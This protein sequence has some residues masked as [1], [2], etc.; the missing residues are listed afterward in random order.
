MTGVAPGEALTT[1]E[2]TLGLAHL[3]TLP[4]TL[5]IWSDIS[6]LAMDTD[7]DD[8]RIASRLTVVGTDWSTPERP[9]QLEEVWAETTALRAGGDSLGS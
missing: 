1:G 9:A 8:L 2:S 6:L 5:P 4:F 3:G 7:H